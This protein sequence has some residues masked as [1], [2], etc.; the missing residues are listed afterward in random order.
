[1]TDRESRER[2]GG[3]FKMPIEWP[4]LCSCHSNPEQSIVNL[5]NWLR[6]LLVDRTP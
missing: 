1:M 5:F 6:V 2:Q 3:N 4:V